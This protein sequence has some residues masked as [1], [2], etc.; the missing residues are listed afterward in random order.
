MLDVALEPSIGDS[1]RDGGLVKV[2][3][4][5]VGEG[6]PGSCRVA[7]LEYKLSAGE[8]VAHL[9]VVLPVVFEPKLESVLAVDPGQLVQELQGVVVVGKRTVGAVADSGERGSVENDVRNSP[10][11]RSTALL[12]RYAQPRNDIGVKSQ[13]STER[14]IEPGVT[15]AGFVY[16]V[17]C[18]GPGIGRGVLFV[19]GDD[20]RPGA[21]QPLRELVFVSPA[22]A[23]HP[24][25]PGRLVVIQPE[26]KSVPI[27]RRGVKLY[28]V[29]RELP[30]VHSRRIV[31]FQESQRDRA[32][33]VT[34][35]LV[36]WK[37]LVCLGII[38]SRA[39]S[40]EVAVEHGSSR[41][42]VSGQE[43]L[44]PAERLVIGHEE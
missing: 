15:E 3:Q 42:G 21:V 11:Y 19:V 2:S 28:I 41:H 29:V 43:V 44:S 4:Q 8:L 31:I 1:D 34:A 33:P 9:I 30:R 22:I 10:G 16:E 40:A 13:E 37:G 39:Q 7:G 38:Y 20:L 5:E 14:V 17:R 36:P 6:I 24:L 12:I 35:N 26:N 18:D 27:E 32:E 23:T 25:G